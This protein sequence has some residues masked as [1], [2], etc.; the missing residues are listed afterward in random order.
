MGGSWLWVS[1]SSYVLRLP[2]GLAVGPGA[3]VGWVWCSP[4][5]GPARGR[6]RCRG[7]P[8]KAV[9]RAAIGDGVR[10]WVVVARGEGP[11]APGRGS[12]GQR[13][14]PLSPRQGKHEHAALASGQACGRVASTTERGRRRAGTL[15]RA[16]SEHDSTSSDPRRA[17][18]QHA[19][20]IVPGA[21]IEG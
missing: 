6:E 13:P 10:C 18:L 19:A 14:T 12:S 2:Q 1:P 5:Y 17:W 15:V 3:L 20:I 4:S 7:R 8:S 11:L 9:V 16:G 21:A